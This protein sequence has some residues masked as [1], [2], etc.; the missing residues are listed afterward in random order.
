VVAR[1]LGI[2][3]A[4]QL[5]AAGLFWYFLSRVLPLDVA[6][7]VAVLIVL[8]VRMAITANNFRLAWRMRSTTPEAHRLDLIGSARLFAQEYVS[9]LLASSWHML[10]HRERLHI[11]LVPRGVPVLLVHGYGANGGFWSPLGALLE[12]ERISHA[13]V[14]LEPMTASIDDYAQQIDHALQALRAATGAEK[15]VIVA[16]SMGGLVSRAYL[17]RHGAAHIARVITLGTPHHGTGLASFGIGSNAQQM[18]LSA[19]WLSQL[20]ADDREQRS[21]FT[22]I[23]SYHDNIIAPQSSCHLPGAKNIAL[24]GIGHVALGSHPTVMQ[25]VVAEILA[26]P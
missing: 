24:G 21:L 9:T 11:A 10:R 26:I 17:R 7:V 16:H 15:I 14:S 25:R 23:Y 1:I 12:R 20:E 3:M 19:V 8:V 6:L 22:S 5:A 18:R 2:I 13:T 4:V